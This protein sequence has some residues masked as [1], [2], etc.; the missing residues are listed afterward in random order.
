MIW[1][2][3]VCEQP[4]R[5]L[6]DVGGLGGVPLEGIADGPLLAVATRHERVPDHTAAD[7][8][9]THQR[10]VETIQCERAVVPV[11]FGTRHADPERVRTA[12]AERRERLLAALERV[13]GRVEL[14][15]RMIEPP[16]ALDG[17]AYLARRRKAAAVH[18]ALAALAVGAT[19]RPERGAAELLRGAYLVERPALPAFTAA[20]ESLQ[21]E[22]P[23]ASLLC[24]G[25]WPAYSFVGAME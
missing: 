9:W 6:P 19:R 23:E 20:V 15:V 7:A 3:A 4:E 18:D 1:L 2:Y 22:H 17:R 24:T 5:P 12:L 10:V 8:L 14:S 16:A 21:R 25:P 13:R 11:R